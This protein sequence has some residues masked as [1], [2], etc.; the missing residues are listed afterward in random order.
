MHKSLRQMNPIDSLQ[1]FV[2]TATIFSAVLYLRATIFRKIVAAAVV[3]VKF[4]LNIPKKLKQQL[5]V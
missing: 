3:V 4:E 1:P 2:T 5:I